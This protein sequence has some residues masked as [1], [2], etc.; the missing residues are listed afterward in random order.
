MAILPKRPASIRS[1]ARDTAPLPRAS[2]KLADKQGLPAAT[3]AHFTG[4]L[5]EHEAL[6]LAGEA[7]PERCCRHTGRWTGAARSLLAEAAASDLPV[8]DLA[9]WK[10][11]R[12]E[13]G[14]LM[15]AGKALLER[16]TFRV[17]LDRDPA[18]RKLVERVVAAAEADALLADALDTWRTHADDAEAAGLSPFDAEGTRTRPWRRSGRLPRATTFPWRCR[19]ASSTSSGSTRARCGRRRWWTA[20]GR[21]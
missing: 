7:G 17:H 12:E 20:G 2:K 6:V 16:E 13:A 9:G 5:E 21:P 18:D 19:R 14:A 8:T 1:M 11:A 15:R 4:M 3:A 10:D